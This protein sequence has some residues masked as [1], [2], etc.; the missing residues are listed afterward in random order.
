[1][2]DS[3]IS[4]LLASHNVFIVE[5]LANRIVGSLTATVNILISKNQVLLIL[6]L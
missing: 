4:H 5:S 2:H 6:C 1:M 3:M